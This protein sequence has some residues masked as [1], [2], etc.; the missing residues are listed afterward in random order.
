[1]SAELLNTTQETL[2]SVQR[3]QRLAHASVGSLQQQ[4][5]VALVGIDQVGE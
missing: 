1:M 5:G 4:F 2:P 3:D